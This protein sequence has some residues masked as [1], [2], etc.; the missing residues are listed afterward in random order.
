VHHF[1]VK[2]FSTFLTFVGCLAAAIAADAG[3]IEVAGL[4]RLPAA[5]V[6]I[7]GE[8]HDNPVHHANQALA[9]RAINPGALVF[10]MLSEAKALKITPGL[11]RSEMELRDTLEWQDSGWPDFSMYY[12]VFAALESAAVFGGD[13]DRRD[14]RRAVSQGAAA[15]FGGGAAIFRLDQALD[16]AEQ[17][18]REAGQM[19][20]HCDTLPVQILP[21]MVEAQRLRDAAI[22]RSVLA[23]MAESGGPVVVITGNGHARADWGV[24]RL[25]RYAMPELRILSVGQFETEPDGPVPYDFW[26][27][28]DPT[29]RGDPCRGLT[30]Q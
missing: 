19:A 13:L 8:I 15:V 3:R 11:L 22:A 1:P 21:G 17:S 5:D 10:E 18:A 16:D 14:V 29:T 9:V 30:G 23:A 26:L 4:A 2:L 20:A 6:M 24:P 27:V 25:L 7:L 28:T 12:P